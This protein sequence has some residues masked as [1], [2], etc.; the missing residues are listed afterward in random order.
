MGL[1]PPTRT[2]SLHLKWMVRR[3]ITFL[4]GRFGLLSGAFDASCKDGTM[5][6]WKETAWFVTFLL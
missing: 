1:K 5:F 2:A 3:P 4:L 6:W